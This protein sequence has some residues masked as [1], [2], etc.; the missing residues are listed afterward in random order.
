LPGVAF[1]VRTA[2][3]ITADL[4][5][6]FAE[7]PAVETVENAKDGTWRRRNVTEAGNPPGWRWGQSGANLSSLTYCEGVKSAG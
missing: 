2:S 5:R 6:I 4:A 1:R 3:N 7:P